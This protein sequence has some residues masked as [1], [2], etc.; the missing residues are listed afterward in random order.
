LAAQAYNEE[1]GARPLRRFIQKEIDNIISSKIINGDAENGDEVK[2]S[3][4]DTGIK[5]KV[6]K[7]GAKVTK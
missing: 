7:V 1:Y 3:A 4:G 2:I 6:A 5:V